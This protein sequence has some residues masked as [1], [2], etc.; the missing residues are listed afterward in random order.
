MIFVDSTKYVSWMRQGWNPVALLASAVSAGE[1]ISCGIIR[2]EVIRGVL[3]PKVKAELS[4]FFDLVPELP[5]S[6]ALLRDAAELA[7]TLDRQGQV[8]PV[9]DVIIAACV[10]RADA[11]LISEDAHFRMVPGLKVR[12]EL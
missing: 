12:A 11:E 7:W 8:L 2:I 9:T 10:K 1:L 3:K 6:A 5:L 4:R